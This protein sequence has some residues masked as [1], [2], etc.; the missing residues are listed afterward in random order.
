MQ[1]E[2][3]PA[4]RQLQMRT[5]RAALD[6]KSSTQQEPTPRTTEPAFL[7]RLPSLPSLLPSPLQ[8]YLKFSH[9][10]HPSH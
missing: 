8:L 1:H 2:R 3:R 4:A 10:L 5:I 7:L 9:F 6:Y